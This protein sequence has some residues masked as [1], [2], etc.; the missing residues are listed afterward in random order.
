MSEFSFP[1]P[2]N[3]EHDV[4]TFDC[5]K[6]PLNAF[7]QHHAFN[8]Q[9]AC[10]SRTYVVTRERF[11]VAYYTLAHVSVSQEDTPKKLGREMPRV[12]P[13]MLLA[14]L[15]VDKTAQGHGLG[16]SLLI[17]ALRRT[18]AVM[19]KGAAPVRLFIVEAKDEEAK[20]F[21]ERFEFDMLVSSQNPMR[22]FLSYKDL[23]PLFADSVE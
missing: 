3:N 14:R 12:I 13:A 10:L 20:K 2:I 18:W 7:L 23:K 9:K 4:S 22:L 6:L 21:Y 5:G 17:D 11:V 19:E 8:K 16:R 1:I 15:A